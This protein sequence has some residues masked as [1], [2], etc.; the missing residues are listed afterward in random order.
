MNLVLCS[1]RESLL[2]LNQ[3]ETLRSSAFIIFK[4]LAGLESEKAIV[5]SSAK[6]VKDK[7]EEDECR[8]L[9]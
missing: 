3:K 7:R 6:S 4:D 1:L 5:V 9:I 2:A 8:S